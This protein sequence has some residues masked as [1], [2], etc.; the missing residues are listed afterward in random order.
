MAD[1]EEGFHFGAD[2]VAG[3]FKIADAVGVAEEVDAEFVE[4]GDE[5]FL[6]VFFPWPGVSQQVALFL[7]ELDDGPFVEH[8]LVV[9]G[10]HLLGAGFDGLIGL[11]ES[12]GFEILPV[13]SKAGLIPRNKPI[14]VWVG[15]LNDANAGP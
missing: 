12:H 10:V 8:G 4:V 11:V 2:A 15:L 9:A 1:D 13:G 6:K 7:D 5:I 3:E 14:Q